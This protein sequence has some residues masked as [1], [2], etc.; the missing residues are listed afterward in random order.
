MQKERP[1]A[2]GPLPSHLRVQQQGLPYKDVSRS[3]AG[4][5][6][7]SRSKWGPQEQVLEG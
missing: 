4:C 2:A 5:S 1:G 3:E 6:I 7:V